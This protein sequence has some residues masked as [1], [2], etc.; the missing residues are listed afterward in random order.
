MKCVVLLTIL[1]ATPLAAQVKPTWNPEITSVPLAQCTVQEVT[2]RME[3]QGIS[4]AGDI[5]KGLLPALDEIGHINAKTKDPNKP[6]GD[7]LSQPDLVRFVELSQRIKVGQLGNYVE[8]RRE[9]DAK[10]LK[11]MVQIADG[12]YRFASYDAE[13]KDAA[14]RD[15]LYAMRDA[16]QSQKWPVDIAVPSPGTCSF[17]FAAK[18]LADEA[19]GKIDG[20]LT[21]KSTAELQRIAAR[22]GM[23]SIDADKLPPADRDAFY[24][25]RREMQGSIAAY[26]YAQDLRNLAW[27]ADAMDINYRAMKQDVIAGGGDFEQI[28]KT[29]GRMLS[30]GQ[31]EPPIQMGFRV[32]SIINEKIP[33]EAVENGS[34]ASAEQK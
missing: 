34:K 18:A 19:I 15:I 32:L 8:S 27:L 31:I 6:V 22:N 3:F 10:V 14:L 23:S 21:A 9:R 29:A 1:T 20:A 26:N 7:Q 28:G 24:R 25:V 11:R 2:A 12:E 30:D 17:Q 5:A 16:A 13:G 33:S 4:G